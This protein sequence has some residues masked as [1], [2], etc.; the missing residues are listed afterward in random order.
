MSSLRRPRSLARYLVY[1]WQPATLFAASFALPIAMRNSTASTPSVK[2][3]QVSLVGRYVLRSVNGQALPARIPLDDGRHSIEVTD[4]F[5]ELNPDGSYLCRTSAAAAYRGL[6]EPFADTLVG[7]YTVLQSGA[8]QLGHK[9]VKADTITTS[10]FKI[11][12]PHPV[13]K[14]QAVFIYIK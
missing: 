13:R 2:A 6:K 8:I 3:A 10:G 9:G 12:W 4:G 1:H 7:G 14:A 11:T 5:L